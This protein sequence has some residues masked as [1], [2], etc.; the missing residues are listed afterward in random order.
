VKKIIFPGS[1][2]TFLSSKK[3]SKNHDKISA[4]RYLPEIPFVSRRDNGPLGVKSFQILSAT[5]FTQYNVVR[6][7]LE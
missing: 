5:T 7:G 6:V 3:I 2:S 4:R 1:Y